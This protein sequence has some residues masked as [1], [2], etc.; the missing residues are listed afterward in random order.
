MTEQEER[1]MFAA[2]AL[3]GLV[4]RDSVYHDNAAKQAW[5]LAEQM[6]FYKP[7]EEENVDK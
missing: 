1:M 5:N 3:A 7:R 4:A 6:M 2:F